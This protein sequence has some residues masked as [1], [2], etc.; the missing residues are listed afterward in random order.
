ME[1][2]LFF[3]WERY[4]LPHMKVSPKLKY[5]ISGRNYS[6]SESQFKDAVIKSFSRADVMRTL[7][8]T[9]GGAN[10]GNVRRLVKQLNLDISHWTG[11]G[12]LKGKTHN[13]T[14][15]RLLSDILVEH[16]TYTSTSKLKK[17]LVAEKIFEDKCFICGLKVW[18][19]KSISLQLDHIN[20]NGED[21]RIENLRLLCPNCHSQTETFCRKKKMVGAE[22]IDPPIPLGSSV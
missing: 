3:I 14:K 21:N 16:S 4:V 20:G 5:K 15:K 6:F 18:N 19:N 2:H 22:G 13:W 12:H 11:Q 8:L 7:N 1:L 9:I 10:Y 17:K